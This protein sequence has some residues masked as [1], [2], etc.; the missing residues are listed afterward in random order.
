[1]RRRH[2]NVLSELIIAGVQK[3]GVTP[4]VGLTNAEEQTAK[5]VQQAT[6]QSQGV[7]IDSH[8]RGT[9]TT[10]NALQSINNQGGIKDESGNTIKPNIQMNNY[11]GAQ[12][13]DTGNQTL[14]Q[15][16]GNKDAQINSV[17]HPND[18][19]GTVIGGNQA[20]PSYTSTTNGTKTE[21]TSTSDGKDPVSNFVNTMM[22]TITPH[23]C[24]GTAKDCQSQ[25]SN[26]PE[27]N[28]PNRTNPDYKA[29]VV[30]PQYQQVDK[31]TPKVQQDS[32]TQMNQLLQPAPLAVPTAPAPPPGSKLETLQNFKKGL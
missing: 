1:L 16:T 9:L 15:V 18:F 28:S 19:I 4:T 11:G 21:V 31:V 6:L 20:T 17:V 2:N 14:Q 23:N 3:S 10:D 22:G 13:N 29:P 5:I 24:Y 27:S 30:I 32:N 12:S 8:S 26:I 25:W 7:V